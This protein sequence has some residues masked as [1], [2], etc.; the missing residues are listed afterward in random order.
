MN[1][2][3][4][5]IFHFLTG[6]KFLV[7]NGMKHLFLL[8]YLLP[9]MAFG[10]LKQEYIWNYT[11]LAE[12]KK[13]LKINSVLVKNGYKLDYDSLMAGHLVV[14]VADLHT[15]AP[16]LKKNSKI[17]I[18][19]HN[20]EVL[21]LR[22]VQLRKQ[23]LAQKEQLFAKTDDFDEAAANFSFKKALKGKRKYTGPAPS[24]WY[25]D[26]GSISIFNEE[27]VFDIIRKNRPVA[28][29]QFMMVPGDM[30]RSLQAFDSNNCSPVNRYSQFLNLK[31]LQ[32]QDVPAK[33]H[34]LKRGKTFSKTFKLNFDYDSY[35]Y[36]QAEVGQITKYLEDSSLTII[37]AYIRGVSSIEGDSLHNTVLQNKRA[38]VLWELFAPYASKG[39][40]IVGDYKEA[41]LQFRTQMKGAGV[42]KFDSLTND[43][44][45][46]LFKNKKYRQEYEPFL[47]KQRIS[48]LYLRLYKKFNYPEVV[49]AAAD[50]ALKEYDKLIKANKISS[51]SARE[52][53]KRKAISAILGIE[54]ALAESVREGS[55][56]RYWVMK[57]YPFD[58]INT[59][60]LT[61][62]RFYLM[63]RNWVKGIDPE[64]LTPEKMILAANRIALPAV[65]SPY[66]SNSNRALRRAVTIQMFA[67]QLIKEEEIDPEFYFALNYPDSPE[68]YHLQ[69]NKLYF[70][71]KQGIVKKDP[72]VAHA[73]LNGGSTSGVT[74][75]SQSRYYYYL[76]KRLI[77]GNKEINAQVLRKDAYYFTDL[78]DLLYPNLYGW[79]EY[80]STFYDDEI[81]VEIMGNLVDRLLPTKLCPDQ[82]YQMALDFHLKVLH[83]ATLASELT[84]QIEKSYQFVTSYYKKRASKI[85]GRTAYNVAAQLVF[86]NHLFYKNES[87]KA[88]YTIMLPAFQ[89]DKL[90]ERHIWFFYDLAKSLGKEN[91]HFKD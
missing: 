76:K 85:D 84:D 70:N 39:T 51:T 20:G 80:D 57:N 67:Y 47:K 7:D 89:E 69:M 74:N 44:I 4:T 15:L 88:A 58:I 42:T 40:R 73:S 71:E 32:N 77:E 14:W 25:M 3:S 75:D 78:F 30:A 6:A 29:L 8:L 50:V 82:K 52:A 10:Q 28:Q 22:G 87:A 48:K 81:D 53:K 56:T 45:R 46:Q 43:E 63:R 2:Q 27:L 5:S 26:F 12:N 37:R 72:P 49:W 34:T 68:Y 21:S 62:A 1:K 17:T 65:T 19:L 35:Q 11:R 13:A 9:L 91:E 55:L 18:T 90:N 36:N 38:E 23:L 41:W 16:M 59:D 54:E 60:Y 31:A 24:T 83:R 66:F 86:L 64:L 61:M 79:N 33:P